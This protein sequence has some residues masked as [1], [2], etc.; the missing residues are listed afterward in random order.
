ML[1]FRRSW[2]HGRIVQINVVSFLEARQISALIAN[3]L[4]ILRALRSSFSF[5][6]FTNH[7]YECILLL[8]ASYHAVN[9]SKRLG[10]CSL[11]A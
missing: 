1:T 2:F 4:L 11:N 7:I 5:T 6:T 3:R 8:T 9:N 10:L